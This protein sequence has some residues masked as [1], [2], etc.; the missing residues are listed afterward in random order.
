MMRRTCVSMAAMV[1]SVVALALVQ[2]PG[3]GQEKKEKK[4]LTDKGFVKTASASDLAEINTSRLAA[5]RASRPDVKKFAM[6]MI[7]D[8]TK[9]SEELLKIADKKGLEPAKEMAKKHKEMFEKLS[10]L[11]GADFDK[12][13]MAGQVKAHDEAVKLFTNASKNLQD[14]ELKAFASKTLPVIQMHH[15]MAKEMSGGGTK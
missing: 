1:L 9:S 14:E 11:Q 7:Q 6:Q 3:A 2:G 10:M 15:K 12:E 8:H 4:Q 13:Y 5:Q